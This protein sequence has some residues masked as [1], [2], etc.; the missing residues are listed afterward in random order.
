M[1][2][3]IIQSIIDF[4]SFCITLGTSSSVTIARQNLNKGLSKINKNIIKAAFK[5]IKTVFKSKFKE[6]IKNGAKQVAKNLFKTFIGKSQNEVNNICVQVYRNIEKRVIN[7]SILPSKEDLLKAIDV[8]EISN[9]VSSCGK[10]DAY[11]CTKSCL[12]TA[13]NFDP[14]LQLQLHL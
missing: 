5:S 2:K 7:K 3:D 10:K 12:E 9:I 8:F 13:K 11:Q 4:I 14:Y 1:I 6:T